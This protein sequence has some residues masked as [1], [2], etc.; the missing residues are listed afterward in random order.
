MAELRI[1][2]TGHKQHATPHRLEQA[3]SKMA[4]AEA[5]AIKA[6]THLW[7][8][9]M[10]HQASDNFLDAIDTDSGDGILDLD[11]LLMRPM[12]GC[13]ICETPYQPLLRRRKCPGV[14]D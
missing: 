8:V 14:R 11:T 9:V 3:E 13:L 6:E 10:T 5:Y 12:V 2:P 1:T 4:A 7:I